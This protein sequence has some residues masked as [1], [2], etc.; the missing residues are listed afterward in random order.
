[1]TGVQTCALPILGI[2]ISKRQLVRLL[3]KSQDA[4]LGEARDVLR[5]GLGAAS[6]ITVDDTGARHKAKNGVCTHIGNDDFAAFVTTGSK[7]RLNFLELLAAGDTTHLINEAALAYMREHNLSGKVIALLSGD[8][9]TS[10]TDR[11]AWTAH[12]TALGITA[13]EV[14][15]DPVRVATEAALGARSP[16]RA[17]WTIP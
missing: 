7:S 13:L 1:M 15:P 5:T 9:S 8:A 4:F 11:E 3:I 14:H 10:F 6:G 2:V 12:L 17:C 16:R